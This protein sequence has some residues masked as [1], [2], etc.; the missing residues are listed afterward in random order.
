MLK[1]KNIK[2]EEKITAISIQPLKLNVTPPEGGALKEQAFV[3]AYAVVQK[4]NRTGYVV[5]WEIVPISSSSSID[6][7]EVGNLNEET[8]SERILKTLTEPVLFVCTDPVLN[9]DDKLEGGAPEAHWLTAITSPKPS[10]HTSLITWPVYFW[11][12]QNA[13]IEKDLKLLRPQFNSPVRYGNHEGSIVAI[14]V[15]PGRS[16]H[17]IDSTSS[18]ESRFASWIVTGGKDGT[19]R[20]WDPETGF[21]RFSH[22]V[23]P[24]NAWIDTLGVVRRKVEPSQ[25]DG[26]W[27]EPIDVPTSLETNSA[28]KKLFVLTTLGKPFT[29]I[30]DSE[31]NT[32]MRFLCQNLHL[33]KIDST[34][35]P[36][37]FD[38][39]N[40]THTFRHGIYGCDG[41]TENPIPRIGGL[42]VEVIRLKEVKFF[43]E[44]FDENLNEGQF[45]NPTSIIFE[46]LL[47]NPALPIPNGNSVHLQQGT[48]TINIHF[49]RDNP[50]DKFKLS[51][52]DSYFDWQ[53]SLTEQLP[54]G[55]SSVLPGRL[56]RIV[57]KVTLDDNGRL[58]LEPKNIQAEVLGALR[59]IPT[60]QLPALVFDK[61]NDNSQKI[62]FR[63][64]L[65]DSQPQLEQSGNLLPF[66]STDQGAQIVA[67]S[68]G[69]DRFDEPVALIA[70]QAGDL[71]KGSAVLADLETGQTR[72]RFTEGLKQAQLLVEDTE[73]DNKRLTAVGVAE[74]GTVRIQR[75]WDITKEAT[76]IVETEIEPSLQNWV[77]YVLPSPAENVQ[78]FEIKSDDQSPPRLWL[79]ARCR[80]GSA[81]L[82]DS[83]HGEKYDL[84]LPNTA[85]TTVVFGPQIPAD[86]FGS[87]EEYQ[88]WRDFFGQFDPKL[89]IKF[90][91]V[92][93]IGGADGSVNIYAVQEKSPVLVRSFF[94]LNEPIQS[95]SLEIDTNSAEALTLQRVGNVAAGLVLLACDS[96]NP[97]QL[98]EVLSG[99]SLIP[100][101]RGDLLPPLQNSGFLGEIFFEDKDELRIILKTVNAKGEF[102]VSSFSKTISGDLDKFRNE[103]ED[104]FA[105]LGI[106][107]PQAVSDIFAR[108]GLLTV[109]SNADDLGWLIYK[110][111][112]S[113]FALLA[114]NDVSILNATTCEISLGGSIQH[115]LITIRT[116]GA[117]DAWVQKD[118]LTKPKKWTPVP[119][120]NL[121]RPAHI[122]NALLGLVT[123]P[124]VA[125]YGNEGRL[126]HVWDIN[127]G[128]SAT[129]WPETLG[130]VDVNTPVALTSVNGV[131]HLAVDRPTDVTVWNLATGKLVYR[132]GAEQTPVSIDIATDLD[133]LWL[134]VGRKSNDEISYEICNVFSNLRK[135]IPDFKGTL[136]NIDARFVTLTSGLNLFVSQRQISSDAPGL[137]TTTLQTKIFRFSL[138]N[139]EITLT[140][141]S[142]TPHLATAL[143]LS[144]DP[145]SL[146]DVISFKNGEFWMLTLVGTQPLVVPIQTGVSLIFPI[147]QTATS[148][149]ITAAFDPD[150]GDL[151]RPLVWTV[152]ANWNSVTSWSLPDPSVPPVPL[153][154]GAS[155]DDSGRQP[156]LKVGES[157]AY[158]ATSRYNGRTRLIA[159]STG[160]LAIWDLLDKKIVH[161]ASLQRAIPRIVPMVISAAIGVDTKAGCIRLWDQYTGRLRQRLFI[162][163]TDI[164]EPKQ[165]KIIPSPARPRLVI[166]GAIK[167]VALFDLYSATTITTA[168]NLLLSISASLMVA[169]SSDVNERIVVAGI[170]GGVVKVW[171][172]ELGQEADLFNKALNLTN[173]PNDPPSLELL[174]LKD[175]M[176]FAVA[177]PKVLKIFDIPSDIPE[178]PAIP[179]ELKPATS[180]DDGISTS[181]NFEI[182]NVRL[183]QALDPDCILAALALKSSLSQDV[184]LELLDL[185]IRKPGSDPLDRPFTR[186]VNDKMPGSIALMCDND[187]PRVVAG[188]EVFRASLL[189]RIYQD[190]PPRFD[191]PVQI[192]N[193]KSFLT[194]RITPS[195]RLDLQISLKTPE[196]LGLPKTVKKLSARANLIQGSYSC[197]LIDGIDNGD[198]RLTG[199][200]VLWESLNLSSRGFQGL[201]LID[202]TNIN[203][204]AT[205]ELPSRPI[206]P[207]TL[208]ATG[209]RVRMRAIP[210]NTESTTI[211]S[212]KW[213]E[214]ISWYLASEASLQTE[215]HLADAVLDIPAE[216]SD[217][218][219]QI[220][221]AIV[222]PSDSN[223]IQ[224]DLLVTLNR[225]LIGSDES[226][227]LSVNPTI[228]A[229]RS[230]DKS[231]ISRLDT[232]QN[233]LVY[234]ATSQGSLGRAF[235][236]FEPLLGQG[237]QAEL[238][239]LATLIVEGNIPK[240]LKVESDRLPL[241]LNT[242]TNVNRALPKHSVTV[243]QLIHREA[244][245]AR[246]RGCWPSTFT[247]LEL[248]DSLGAALANTER[249]Q[250]LLS[251]LART[252][253]GVMAL[254]QNLLVL[255]KGKLL[256]WTRLQTECV[257][258]IYRNGRALF[259]RLSSNA[260]NESPS[261]LNLLTKTVLRSSGAIERKPITL[262]DDEQIQS[263]A[264][265]TGTKGV[266]L[267]RTADAR[268]RV[269]YHLV[270]SPYYSLIPTT[271]KLVDDKKDS[272]ASVPDEG[273]DRVSPDP[274]ILSP[275]K[276][277]K[278]SLLGS[279]RYQP[280]M[281]SGDRPNKRGFQIFDKLSEKTL[282]VV[283]LAEIPALKAT[284][285]PIVPVDFI[286][287]PPDSSEVFLPLKLELSFGLTKPGGTFHQTIQCLSNDNSTLAPLTTFA[288]R[289]S[290]QF[291]PPLRSAIQLDNPTLKQQQNNKLEI[292]LPWTEIIGSVT[293]QNN[294]LIDNAEFVIESDD[295]VPP[296]FT[297]KEANKVLK[298]IVRLGEKIQILDE[299]LPIPFTPFLDGKKVDF[300]DLLL[301]TRIILDEE[302]S[303]PDGTKVNPV[304]VLIDNEK[305]EV[306]LVKL[307]AS[308][309]E[310]VVDNQDGY[311]VW[312]IKRD[313]SQSPD[314]L[315]W[316]KGFENIDSVDL[317]LIWWDTENIDDDIFKRVPKLYPD[318]KG[319]KLRD[320]AYEP[321]LPR[322][323]AILR[324][325]PSAGQGLLAPSREFTLFYCPA[326]SAKGI[327]PTIQISSDR[328][329]IQFTAQDAEMIT[330]TNS[331]PTPP[332]DCGI[333]IVKYFEDGA[334]LTTSKLIP[335][336]L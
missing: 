115:Y 66:P 323:A 83:I 282:H 277:S 112:D 29:L 158:L 242:G 236:L 78:V 260:D 61:G 284:E 143:S 166:G 238:F 71:D 56:A 214:V 253:Q 251:P 312:K 281:V 188:T 21:E 72:T 124:M 146:L 60:A 197:F 114:K 228:Y 246:I 309:L 266:L 200:L 208:E 39:K 137:T 129:V 98:I 141:V 196:K 336:K 79:L 299:S 291:I 232:S 45:V 119:N 198:F 122:D 36:I 278:L 331:L 103:F 221:K 262:F 110:R 25:K 34:W 5:T 170:E 304:L 8:A 15:V 185:P 62:R 215:W 136:N 14:A 33:S 333:S 23:T 150:P 271:I 2:A 218:S 55:K 76:K 18:P 142:G 234:P 54:L 216:N 31:S 13:V 305:R 224:G 47:S 174:R 3:Y 248:P 50:G 318:D 52:K 195:R 38:D 153:T 160:R 280:V 182:T 74:D 183:T 332:V 265:S 300:F 127:E 194:G 220:V 207:F 175:R 180:N 308:I 126:G 167:G 283:H 276:I 10:G 168:P 123:A 285:N 91:T 162:K 328:A 163:N 22:T 118:P 326:A 113:K 99:L 100:D 187:G 53:F 314:F 20:I 177:E 245:G 164:N 206:S 46:A 315:E 65:K 116:N 320:V 156:G 12:R 293:L 255:P 75:L 26:F 51:L 233:D 77:H 212:L 250:W 48:A 49:E 151:E 288:R 9:D 274:R 292:E 63:E 316:L 169:E 192:C 58:R 243:P 57:G 173:L 90:D 241:D 43:K 130:S 290:Q 161:T 1:I 252:P 325:P 85:V 67:T 81:W 27:I 147:P 193:D 159:I 247:P 172:S 289:E 261:M 204:K 82:W 154:P 149:P 176:L 93:A 225:T 263:Y 102:N 88:H 306:K 155:I 128:I 239:Q 324:L 7:L 42:P 16:Q 68:I 133:R 86:V 302:R 199:A 152:G 6:S 313:R 125:C 211:D 244:Q 205:V 109:V 101:Q 235:D 87:K 256:N 279:P 190:Q 97:I 108:N 287:T 257:L 319:L 310:K 11:N 330:L 139:T 89:T 69:T 140:E 117:L 179:T 94:V 107:Q 157:P 30:E 80:D 24:S 269:K 286:E 273:E 329:L 237:N 267:V 178:M 189:L 131:P 254:T 223:A 275:Q 209:T 4:V 184:R 334:T 120:S 298:W 322:L 321:Q 295:K 201:L 111:N 19:V 41:D 249:S 219:R 213:R 44:N 181:N 191:L 40:T 264:L 270:N 135:E 106:Q 268:S 104:L 317:N 307:L 70:S 202:D 132:L 327:T 144:E 96:K 171:R 301:V 229:V 134:L 297:I 240:L 105:L 35:E 145:F 335:V 59:P 37:P 148:A 303:L 217:P 138:S 226:Y 294:D 28:S 210:F 64:S 258:V 231:G 32:A 95:L 92:V 296:N 73:D 165:L 203:A 259:D 186:W 311:Y 84:S 222:S 227:T 121:N 272:L 17:P 230:F